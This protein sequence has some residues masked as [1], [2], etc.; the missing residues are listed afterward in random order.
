MAKALHKV[1]KQIAKKKGGK[2]N[3]LHENSRDS[4]RLR[5]AGARED[6][7]AR[8]VAAASRA[9]QIYGISAMYDFLLVRA[10]KA[11]LGKTQ[12]IASRSFKQPSADQVLHL[13][14][15]SFESGRQGKRGAVLARFQNRSTSS[16]F[17]RL[18]TFFLFF[19][20]RYVTRDAEE[21]SSLRTQRRPGRPPTSQEDQLQHRMDGEEK[22]FK[23]GFWVPDLLDAEGVRKLLSWAGDW[24]SLNTLKFIRIGKERGIRPSTFPPKGLS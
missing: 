3:S 6:K 15:R 9:N 14:K 18:L 1:Q 8:I 21:L 12:L 2:T 5:T 13:A 23:S 24:S 16:Y 7:I 19:S 17:D 11:D 10:R 22:E 20:Q 4:Q